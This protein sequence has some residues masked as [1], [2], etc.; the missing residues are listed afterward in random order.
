M[1]AQQIAD[2]LDVDLNRLKEN[3]EAM[4]NF[5]ASIRKGRAKGE[6]E[7]RAALFKLARKGDAFAL[8]EC[9]RKLTAVCSH[10]TRI[11]N[12]DAHLI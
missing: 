5:Y 7:L 4:T 2:V 10:Q 8:R 1:T 6:A 3:R 11:G 12:L 9:K